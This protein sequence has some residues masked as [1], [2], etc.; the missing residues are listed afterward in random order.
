MKKI[1]FLLLTILP[2][3]GCDPERCS[4]YYINNK[5][6]QDISLNYVS[7]SPNFYKKIIIGA[8]S[9]DLFSDKTCAIGGISIDIDADSIY[10][11]HEDEILKIWKPDSEGK[12][13]YNIERDWYV[14]ESP[15]D[16]FIYIFEITNEDLNR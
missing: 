13:I 5:S 8:D 2:L 10:L 7:K 6:A 12:N 14:R 9:N 15:K 16:N 4:T 11:S 1:S 3:F